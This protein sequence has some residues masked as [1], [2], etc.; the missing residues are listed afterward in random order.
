MFLTVKSEWSSYQEL[1]DNVK[2]FKLPPIH[3]L[4]KALHVQY[5]QCWNDFRKDLA[6]ACSVVLE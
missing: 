4:F 1:V 6:I 5:A 2:P 3:V